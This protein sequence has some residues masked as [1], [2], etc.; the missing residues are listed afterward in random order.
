MILSPRA[1]LFLDEALLGEIFARRACSRLASQMVALELCSFDLG[2]ASKLLAGSLERFPRL[3]LEG[4]RTHSML[5]RL[6]YKIACRL[7]VRFASP[8][9]SSLCSNA[10]W[11]K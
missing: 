6:I 4:M 11:V 9:C 1:S 8:M 5:R 2:F 10:E 7:F 3:L